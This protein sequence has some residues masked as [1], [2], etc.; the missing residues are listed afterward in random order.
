M[1]SIPEKNETIY[2]LIYKA[3]TKPNFKNN[4]EFGLFEYFIYP[5]LKSYKI[6]MA[7]KAPGFKEILNYSGKEF[8][9]EEFKDYTFEE[10]VKIY[11]KDYDVSIQIDIKKFLPLI[12]KKRERL[13]EEE[14][15]KIKKN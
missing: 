15:K 2:Q 6:C 3:F 5:I 1:L 4:Y 10:N 7:F 12:K 13:T 11:D 8:L 9:Q 14:K